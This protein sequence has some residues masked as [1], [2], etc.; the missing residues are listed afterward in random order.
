MV[1]LSGSPGIGK[2]S[3]A[4]LVSRELDLLGLNASD[5]RNKKRMEQQLA[6]AVG[7]RVISLGASVRGRVVIMDEVTIVCGWLC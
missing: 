1:V 7:C 2:T 6:E 3:L 5:C 4:G